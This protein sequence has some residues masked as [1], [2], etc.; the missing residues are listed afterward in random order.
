MEDEQS[1][2]VKAVKEAAIQMGPA[3]GVVR[4]EAHKE[5]DLIEVFFDCYGLRIEVI[6]AFIGLVRYKS[7][8]CG[9][10]DVIAS[11]R[12]GLGLLIQF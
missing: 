10:I 2:P 4:V 5:A 8:C 6:N 11:Q 1:A 7:A 3:I 12:N 9:S